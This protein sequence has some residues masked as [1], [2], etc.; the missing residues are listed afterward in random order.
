MRQKVA[1]KEKDLTELLNIFLNI[2]EVNRGTP[3]GDDDRILDAEGLALKFYS[4]ALSALYI[5]RGVNLPDLVIPIRNFPDPSSLDVLVRAAFETYLVFFH[6]FIDPVDGDESDFKFYSW[7][8]AGLYGRQ[9]YRA[10][11]KENI[12]KLKDEFTYIKQLEKKLEKN[13]I[14]HR[15]TIKQREKYKKQLER[16]NWRSKGW[17][18]IA[19]DAGFSELN[20]KQIYRFLC[21]HAH[22]GNISVTQVRQATDFQFRKELMQASLGHLLICLANMIKDYC[23]YFE[24]SRK[25]YLEH[26]P[27]PNIVEM[28]IDIGANE[29]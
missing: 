3:T 2:V 1:E 4:H 20:A 27:S 25:Y 22:S 12:K 5:L 11:T 6:V 23:D 10:S 8:I 21:E 14:V 15:K 19:Q 13:P 7:E 24:R 28:W 9:N 16:G 26:Y 17:A 18:E 29:S